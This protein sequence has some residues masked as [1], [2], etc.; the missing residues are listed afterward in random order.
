MV[1][2]TEARASRTAAGY[3]RIIA[4][5]LTWAEGRP[6]VRA[7]VVVGSRART[8]HP[9]DDWADLDVVVFASDP[10]RYV[11][12]AGWANAMGVPWIT[13]VEP[14][15]AGD[16]RERR[17]LFEKGFDVD[18]AFFPAALLDEMAT[19]G[20]PDPFADAIR[21]GVRILIDREG[22]FAAA[23]A[24]VTSAPRGETPSASEFHALV[25]DF[26]YHA[27]WTAKHLRRGEL[28][29][30]KGT[31]DQYMKE[32]LRRMMEWHAR[33][34]HGPGHDTWMRGRFLE[35][36]TD[37]RAREALAYAFAHYDEADTWRA[38][39]ATMSLFRW[40]ARETS[41]TLGYPYPADEDRHASQL[42][43]SLDRG[44]RS[45]KR[46]H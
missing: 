11:D 30:A 14:T 34:V 1:R 24:R 43:R 22:A 44:T 17:V 41:T 8:D 2:S 45:P 16:S 40:L 21:R 23:T 10:S 26:W 6:D 7:A 20:M 9:A 5:F 28:W 13:F 31:C 37:P 35:E 15:A 36:W 33:S 42:V 3:E 46:A 18:F 38:L 4:K 29:W 19:G 27:V 12:D 25:S 39:L 32:L